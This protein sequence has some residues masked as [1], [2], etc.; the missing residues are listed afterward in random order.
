VSGAIVYVAAF[1]LFELL[2][3][4]AIVVVAAGVRVW[5]VWE[6]WLLALLT[7]PVAISLPFFIIRSIGGRP[8]A[9]VQWPLLRR[10]MAKLDDAPLRT[11]A[12]LR[13]VFFLSPPITSCLALSGVPFTQYLM[14]SVIGLAIPL[15]LL[16]LFLNQ[17]LYKL[18]FGE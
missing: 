1:C 17:V 18:G 2:H 14:G 4:P 5:G 6:G 9:E 15:T 10:M 16:C 7:A 11:V 12:L 3:L 8:L 13:L